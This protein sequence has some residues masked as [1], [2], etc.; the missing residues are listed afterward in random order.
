MA[1]GKKPPMV[2]FKG[3]LKR[4]GKV[5]AVAGVNLGI[6]DGEFLILVGPSGCGKSTILRMLAGLEEVTS[7]ESLVDGATFNRLNDTRH[8]GEPRDGDHGDTDS[9]LRQFLLQRIQIGPVKL[10]GLAM[11]AWRPMTEEEHQALLACF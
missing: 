3:I 1:T 6:A 7:G 4:F 9:P 8:I 2:Q 11:G 5:V 10:G